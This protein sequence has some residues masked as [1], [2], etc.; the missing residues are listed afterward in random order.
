MLIVG[1]SLF[2]TNLEPLKLILFGILPYFCQSRHLS[3]F[4]YFKVDL[5]IYDVNQVYFS[6]L[7]QK[8]YSQQ[9]KIDYFDS[10]VSGVIFVYS[11]TASNTI[12]ILFSSFSLKVICSK[13]NTCNSKCCFNFIAA[14]YFRLQATATDH[15]QL[16]ATCPSLQI[17]QKFIGFCKEGIS[18]VNLQ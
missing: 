18:S 4:I 15:T 6:V 16:K 10:G 2:F 12:K 7:I 9:N 3:F 13:R 8:V 14:N 5:Q 1:E 17:K 11:Q